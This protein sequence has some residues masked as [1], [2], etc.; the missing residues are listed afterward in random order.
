MYMVGG[1]RSWWLV[2]NSRLRRRLAHRSD[3]QVARPSLAGLPLRGVHAALL[4]GRR[5]AF[6]AGGRLPPGHRRQRR[7]RGPPL[8][9]PGGALGPAVREGVRKAAGVVRAAAAAA[10]AG[11]GA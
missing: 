2:C 3:R 9:A 4:R 10:G 6:R 11:V 5:V 8:V 7:A 1:I